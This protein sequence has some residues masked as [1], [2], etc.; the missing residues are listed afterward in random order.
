[1][2]EEM[3][4]RVI[5]DANEPETEIE[6][7]L[8]V[9][10][11]QNIFGSGILFPEPPESITGSHIS[12]PAESDDEEGTP[13][14]PEGVPDGGWGWVIVAA[15][16]LMQVALG[17]GFVSFGILYVDLV[18][19]FGGQSGPIGWIGSIYMFVGHISSKYAFVC[20]Y[21]WGRGVFHQLLCS[22]NQSKSG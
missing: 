20:K 9:K 7:R 6:R 11:K 18:E 5:T 19:Q 14:P 1:M 13:R 15:S 10:I 22:S 4:Q 12:L 21:R 8:N 16:F 17:L 3:M 2:H